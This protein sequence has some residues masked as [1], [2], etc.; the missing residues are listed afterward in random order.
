MSTFDSLSSAASVLLHDRAQQ[1]ASS[2]LAEQRIAQIHL[3]LRDAARQCDNSCGD[4]ARRHGE[5]DRALLRG[6]SLD[7]ELDVVQTRLLARTSTARTTTAQAQQ[8]TADL[9]VVTD[10]LAG[11]TPSLIQTLR[12]CRE[13]TVAVTSASR[14]T[15][16][17]RS[18][19]RC[20]VVAFHADAVTRVQEM[21]SHRNSV[22]AQMFAET[23]E[24]VDAIA[25]DIRGAT[26][27][28]AEAEQ[29]ASNA[30]TRLSLLRAQQTDAGAAAHGA[31]SVL[32]DTAELY[33]EAIAKNH[34]VAGELAHRSTVLAALQQDAAA[35]AECMAAALQRLSA[36]GEA[37]TETRNAAQ[38]ALDELAGLLGAKHAA[39]RHA[40]TR[41]AAAAAQSAASISAVCERMQEWRQL[42]AALPTFVQALVAVAEAAATR[43]AQQRNLAGLEWKLAQRRQFIERTEML[44]A[45]QA[46]HRGVLCSAEEDAAADMGRAIARSLAQHVVADS[47]SKLRAAIT[48]QETACFSTMTN[49][50]RAAFIGLRALQQH[51]QQSHTHRP[52]APV[53][54]R[55]Q[56]R[57]HAPMAAPRRVPTMQPSMSSDESGGWLFDADAAFAP[58]MDDCDGPSPAAKPRQPRVVP[59]NSPPP[60]KP[61][62]LNSNL[63]GVA[64]PTAA[65][66][67]MPKPKL[68]RPKPPA[69]RRKAA[70]PNEF[71]VFVL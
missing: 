54:K 65:K 70:V 1:A 51:Q 8:L 7:D 66:Q 10:S 23:T 11:I 52:Q 32:H 28:V 59:S 6:A 15:A 16:A 40:E 27:A 71:D 38:A 2:D 5:L 64:P 29:R 56:P 30:S 19:D 33:A 31:A 50:C 18:A 62:W 67:L 68:S 55:V 47:E 24:R 13:R 35:E 43:G 21:L 17:L 37:A 42:H 22:C 57:R 69:S 49:H 4:I 58:A 46:L 61:S 34:A 3:L 60:R 20:A 9:R 26:I 36:E 39:L 14:C 53:P 25:S 63:H 48:A 45:E 41:F 44:A 12:A